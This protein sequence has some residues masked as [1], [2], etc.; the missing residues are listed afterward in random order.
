MIL[1]FLA[2]FYFFLFY[3]PKNPKL[4]IKDPNESYKTSTAVVYIYNDFFP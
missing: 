4:I 1:F 2:I 3:T